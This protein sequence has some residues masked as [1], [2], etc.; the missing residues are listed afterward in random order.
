MSRAIGRAPFYTPPIRL[1]GYDVGLL[2]QPP[3]RF[4]ERF[5]VPIAGAN[6]YFREVTPDDPW[7][8]A[9]L[10]ALEPSTV[11]ASNKAG[12]INPKIYT[13]RALRGSDRRSACDT[14]KYGTTTAGDLPAISYP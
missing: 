4:A 3:D 11:S 8:E 10:C 12:S 5:A 6:E 14:A 7:V 13:K 9:L 1:W 2:T